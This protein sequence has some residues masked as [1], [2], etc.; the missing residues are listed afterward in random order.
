MTHLDDTYE[1]AGE[2]D[3]L[4]IAVALTGCIWC[5]AKF[6]ARKSGG[7]AQWFCSKDCRQDFHVA[8]RTWAVQEYESGRV[9][10]T[11][12][13]TPLGQRARCI[14]RNLDPRHPQA[15]GEPETLDASLHGPGAGN[16]EYRPPAVEALEAA[17][18]RALKPE[19]SVYSDPW[20]RHGHVRGARLA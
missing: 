8:R 13:R 7:S 17:L 15:P 18:K 2:H 5:K 9:S 11:A 10:L 16:I 4:A 19:G 3:D 12:L 1:S 6:A 14:E 20:F